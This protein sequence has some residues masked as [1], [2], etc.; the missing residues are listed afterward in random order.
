MV[1]LIF[2][3]LPR[4]L[5]SRKRVLDWVKVISPILDQERWVLPC[6]SR[7]LGSQPAG[8]LVI[9]PVVGCRYFP[10]GPNPQECPE[11]WLIIT[12]TLRSSF[13]F[14][15]HYSA[16]ITSPHVFVNI[17]CRNVFAIYMYVWVISNF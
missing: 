17:G 4:E 2:P 8:D 5:F 14:W 9:N 7:F 10:Q 16:L 15:L 3:I 13:S 11:L 6:V 1:G 12:I